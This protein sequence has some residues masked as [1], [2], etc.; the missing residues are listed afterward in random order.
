[1]SSLQEYYDILLGHFG[2]QS[3]WPGETTIE[4]IV[5][6]VLTQNTNWHNVEKAIANLKRAHVLDFQTLLHLPQADLAAYI[7]PSGYYNLK[8][9]RLQNLLVYI[10]SCL[11]S[12]QELDSF[13]NGETN[14]LREQLLHVKGIGPETADSILLYAGQKPVF[15]IDAYA[16]R[17]L[18]RH[19]FVGEETSY[20]E[21]QE[22]MVD[23]LPLDAPLFNEFHALIVA[24]GKEF[25]KKNN[26]QCSDCPLVDCLP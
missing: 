5:G 1:M 7:R 13:F 16:Y 14:S 8:A 21:M 18:F 24:V 2:S 11:D 25:C 4:V 20:E 6:A 15:V 26:P 12:E 22:V 17:L 9:T 10:D 3:W 19:G 23:A